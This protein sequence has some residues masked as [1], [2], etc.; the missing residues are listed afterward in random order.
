MENGLKSTVLLADVAFQPGVDVGL[1]QERGGVD[2]E[3]SFGRGGG[4]GASTG[5]GDG[6]KRRKAARRQENVWENP[7]S[8]R[9]SWRSMRKEGRDPMWNLRSQK[10]TDRCG[11]ACCLRMHR[12]G[13]GTARGGPESE[14]P[15]LGSAL[16]PQLERG[17]TGPD[18]GWFQTHPLSLRSPRASFCHS[19]HTSGR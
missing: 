7:D 3:A 9:G 1:N 2:K 5:P 15:T 11:R 16:S 8:G 6:D 4:T 12:I 18:C 19:R 14:G 17:Q 10:G 13:E